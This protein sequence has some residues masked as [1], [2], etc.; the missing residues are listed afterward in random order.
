MKINKLIN[1][2]F[3]KLIM[4]LSEKDNYFSIYMKKKTSSQNKNK[5]TVKSKSKS[6][7]VKRASSSH[8][9]IT[10][11]VKSNTSKINTSKISFSFNRR[12]Y[13]N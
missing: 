7:S 2:K 6:K 13:K 3:Q 10:T 12:I 5:K 11:K 9:N 1:K 8:N 4:N